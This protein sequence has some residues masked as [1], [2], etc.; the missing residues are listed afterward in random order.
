MS[1][2]TLK[3]SS[4]SRMRSVFANLPVTARVG[5]I[6]RCL[7]HT[8]IPNAMSPRRWSAWGPRR[9][10][11][12]PMLVETSTRASSHLDNSLRTV[13]PSSSESD[14]SGLPRRLAFCHVGSSRRFAPRRTARN[15]SSFNDWRVLL[16]ARACLEIACNR[17]RYSLAVLGEYLDVSV[18][19]GISWSSSISVF[20]SLH[21]STRSSF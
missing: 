6:P 10:G 5:R 14:P 9:P 13:R 19:L 11:G 17:P 3:P 20:V 1:S 7:S 15:Q 8:P 16:N 18:S 12:L 4:G 2:G 21:F